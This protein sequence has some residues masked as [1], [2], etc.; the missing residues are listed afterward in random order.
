[1]KI[2]IEKPMLKSLAMMASVIEARDA[3]TGG[4]LW[5]QNTAVNL[6]PPCWTPSFN[7]RGFPPYK[8]LSGPVNAVYAWWSVRPAAR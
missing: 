3:Y 5:R 7:G 1:M 4:H 8:R 2:Q 6:M